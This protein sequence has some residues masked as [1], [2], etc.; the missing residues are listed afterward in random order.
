MDIR[1]Y[2]TEMNIKREKVLNVKKLNLI[3]TWLQQPG[4]IKELI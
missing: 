1:T 4:L 3:K 2:K